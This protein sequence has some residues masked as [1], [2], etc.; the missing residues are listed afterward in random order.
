MAIKTVPAYV[1]VCD[2]CGVEYESDFTTWAD[3]GEA[4]R[5]P[6]MD[7]TWSLLTVEGRSIL[8]C[9]RDNA[10]DIEGCPQCGGDLASSEWHSALGRIVQECA[11]C[12]HVESVEVPHADEFPEQVLVPRPHV[13]N[14][15]KGIPEAEA[16]A[17][18]LRKAARNLRDH[19]KPFGSTLRATVVDLLNAAADAVEASDVEGGVHSKPTLDAQVEEVRAERDQMARSLAGER[20]RGDR[21]AEA[22][23]ALSEKVRAAGREDLLPS[24]S[25]MDHG[26]SECS[27]E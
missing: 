10:P 27:P 6:Y 17:D 26:E 13:L 5:T 4:L 23:N 3:R 15:P 24:I 25:E 2:A 19:Y 16:D 20:K 1:P 8:L 21:I 11:S 22:W 18:Y 7:D 14:G 12:G 9:D